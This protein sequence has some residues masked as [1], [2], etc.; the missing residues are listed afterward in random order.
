MR[1]NI[2]RSLKVSLILPYVLLVIIVSLAL[3]STYYWSAKRNIGEFSQRYTREVASRTSQSISFR[4]K[5]SDAVLASA[6]P[7]NVSNNM[8]ISVH[9]RELRT[10]FWVATSISNN[11]HGNVYYVNEKGQSIALKRLD[12]RK[13]RFTV[14]L[15]AEQPRVHYHYRGMYGRPRIL[16]VDQSRFD[17]RKRFW[18][19]RARRTNH[20]IWSGVYVDHTTD[21]L[22]VTR[23]RRVLSKTGEFAGVVATDIYLRDINRFLATLDV[24]QAGRAFVVDQYGQVI[25]AP[26]V[27]S[28]TAGT[29]DAIMREAAVRSDDPIIRAAYRHLT[30]K[31]DAA[32][33]AESTAGNRQYQT[34][35]MTENG[36]PILVAAQRIIGDS[37]LSW[38][39]VVAIPSTAVLTSINQQFWVALGISLLAVVIAIGL[40][41]FI[42]GR[43]ARDVRSLSTAVS[44][45]RDGELDLRVDIERSDEVGDLARNFKAMHTDLFTDRLTGIPNRTA[46]DSLLESLTDASE[47]RP[48]TLFFIDL[49]HFKPLNDRYGHDNGDRALTEVARRLQASMRPDDFVARLGGDEFVAIAMDVVEADAISTLL[50]KLQAIVEQPLRTLDG[51]LH[52]ETIAVGAAVG[53]AT[54]PAEAQDADGLLKCADERMYGAKPQRLTA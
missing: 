7:E 24:A 54:W 36:Q 3:S 10:R 47:K 28:S 41:M 50:N 30:A 9:F 51:V 48:F 26:K 53:H 17:P 32:S 39:A 12:D 19:Q 31:I 37:G 29:Q 35:G 49:N 13:A 1:A 33:P 42:F 2:F 38:M 20:A 4:L 27:F 16:Y 45:T 44:R 46:L 25:A 5:N 43:I 52:D 6:F 18:Y 23:A 14:R 15:N 8:D 34:T 40:G 11:A 22:V 21:S